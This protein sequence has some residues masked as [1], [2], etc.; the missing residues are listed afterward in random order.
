MAAHNDFGKEAEQDA[1]DYLIGQGHI[2]RE[3]NYTYS[4]AEIDIISQKNN[5]LHI[6]EVKARNSTHYG[7]PASFVSKQKMQLL[8]KA[9]NHYII[10]NDLDVEVQFDIIAI[11]KN[12]YEFTL[13]H[14]E[15]AFYPFG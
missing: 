5:T 9:A 7:E 15:D 4:H 14:I 2:V 13:E 1:V 11:V 8:A 10:K 6:V 12:Q 3:R